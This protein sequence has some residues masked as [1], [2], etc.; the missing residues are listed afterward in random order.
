M[1]RASEALGGRAAAASTAPD[2]LEK[3]LGA[4]A[5]VMLAFVVAAVLRGRDEW[6]RVPL[7]VWLHLATIVLALALTPMLLWR[8]RGTTRHRVL[9]YTWSA[10]M[11]ATAIDSFLVRIS[12]PGHLGPIHALSF[13]TLV[14]VPLLVISARRHDV[15]RHRRT[16]RGLIIGALLIAGFFTFPF[17]RLLGHWLFG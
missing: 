13:L 5:L 11:L 4:L 17:H 6:A 3:V 8:A 7:V 14:L 9:G 10:A 16:V 2:K 15:Y 12:H 1:A